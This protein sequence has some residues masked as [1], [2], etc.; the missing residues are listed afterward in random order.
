M[1]NAIHNND[2]YMPVRL[3]V[4][5]V[6]GGGVLE[7]RKKLDNQTY[8]TMM[9]MITWDLSSLQKYNLYNYAATHTQ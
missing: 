5:K 1:N 7:C 3:I 9:N 8:I 4:I 2:T 6:L